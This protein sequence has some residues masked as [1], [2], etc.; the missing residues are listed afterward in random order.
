[1]PKMGTK[2]GAKNEHQFGPEMVQKLVQK[3][4]KTGPEIVQN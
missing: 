1:V 3:W 4:S 2:I